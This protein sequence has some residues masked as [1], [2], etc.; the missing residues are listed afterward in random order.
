MSSYIDGGK[1]WAECH[2]HIGLPNIKN[3][4]NLLMLAL[5]IQILELEIQNKKIPIDSDIAMIS[6]K[7]NQF[8]L[9]ARET[10]YID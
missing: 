10:G 3:K 1:S 5:E 6:E 2:C 7:I 9:L 4:L 8:V